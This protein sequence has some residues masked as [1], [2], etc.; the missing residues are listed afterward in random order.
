MD[1]RITTRRATVGD[2]MMR[3]ADERARRLAKYDPRLQAVSLVF[4]EDHGDVTVE[5]RAEVPGVPPLV[6]RSAGDSNRSALDRALDKLRRQLRRE[7]KKRIEHQ[8]P[9]AGAIVE[10]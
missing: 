7:R 5:I 9:P 4:E 6:A 2:A 1:V 10:E 3:R 8:A